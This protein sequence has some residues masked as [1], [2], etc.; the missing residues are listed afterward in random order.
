MAREGGGKG[1]RWH[2]LGFAGHMISVATI[3]VCYCH[4]KAATEMIRHGF[5]FNK[6]LQKTGSGQNSICGCSLRPSK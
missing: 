3:Q 4:V 1:R 5:C 2:I 6:T